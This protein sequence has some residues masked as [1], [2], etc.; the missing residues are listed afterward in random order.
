MAYDKYPLQIVVLTNLFN[1]LIYAIGIIILQS[2]GWL[3]AGLFIAYIIAFEIRLLKYHCPDCYY[4]GKV[5]GFGKG[6]VSSLFFKKG[7]PKKF[8]CKE[9]GYKDLIPDMLVFFIPAISGKIIA[10]FKKNNFP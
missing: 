4:Y 9:I 7:D 3:Y 8:T 5:C 2:I 10:K 6:I 1:L